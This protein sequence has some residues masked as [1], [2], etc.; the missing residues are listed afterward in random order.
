VALIP[1]ATT[2]V[3]VGE[4]LRRPVYD[5][6]GVLLLRQGELVCSEAQKKGLLQRG[7]QREI[8]ETARERRAGERLRE[9]CNEG[10]FGRIGAL[11]VALHRLHAELLGEHPG[12]DLASRTASI[13]GSLQAAIDEDADA[14]LAAMQIDAHEDGFV[15]RHLH[16]AVLCELIGRSLGHPPA[17][18]RSLACAALTYDIGL[19]VLHEVLDAQTA[20]LSAEQR[21]ELQAH[22][23][24][25]IELLQ[26]AGVDDPQWLDAVRQ[27]HERLDGSGYPGHLNETTIGPCAR[28][29]A[30]ADIYTA[31]IRPRAHRHAVQARIALRDIFLERG[32]QVDEDLAAVFIKELGIYPPGSFVRLRNG[33]IAVVTRRR[34]D[35]AHPALRCVVARDGT[36]IARP[37]PRDCAEPETAIVEVVETTSFRCVLGGIERLWSQREPTPPAT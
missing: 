32:R 19:A 34:A 29:L 2:D 15:E 20:P 17:R 30:I 28:M 21:S 18:R 26:A 8:D 6:H 1:L 33:E 35:A 36:P 7:F 9:T 27:H 13:A 23:Q 12:S 5:R 37:G 4:P 16:V 24:R 22:P 14:V 31:M 10:M 11:A 25:S 3:R